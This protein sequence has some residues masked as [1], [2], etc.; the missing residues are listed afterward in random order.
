[1]SA[2]IYFFPRL[3]K[4]ELL[5]G[6][7]DRLIG[8]TLERYGLL[9]QFGDVRQASREV[10]V[11]ETGTQLG[12]DK[13]HSGVMLSAFTRQADG[14]MLAGQRHGYFPHLQTWHQ[15]LDAND[16]Q[17]WIGVDNDSPPQPNARAAGRNRTVRLDGICTERRERCAAVQARRGCQ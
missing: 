16:T 8:K 4:A 9:E 2:L 14:S 10:A 12:P 6:P 5:H 3:A 17:L 11:W 13:N 15:V 7:T 1:M